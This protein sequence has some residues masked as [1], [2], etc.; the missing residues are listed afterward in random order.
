MQTALAESDAKMEV[1]QKYE[2]TQ[3]AESSIEANEQISETKVNTIYQPPTQHT[4]P[5]S[6][7]ENKVHLARLQRTRPASNMDLNDGP[8]LNNLCKAISQQVDVTEYLVK[9]HKAT[10]LP[11]LTIPTFKG[12]P[13]EYKSFIRSIEHGVEDRTGDSRDRLQFLLQYTSG[14]PHELVKSCI[15]MESSAGYAKAKEM[16][17]EFYGDDYKIAEAYIKEALDW[18][19]I[20]SE[21]GA[22]LQSFALF[23]TGCFNTMTDISYMEDLDNTANIKALANKLPY[24]LKEAWRKSACDQQEKTKKKGEIQGFCRICQQ[25]S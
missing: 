23:L 20:K 13:L 14:Q 8:V 24:K 18:Q 10:L 4:P 9:N 7:L 11:E 12:D 25:A 16:L 5:T 6:K 19:T 3:A 22:A 1:L 2:C 17:K 21:D 15:H